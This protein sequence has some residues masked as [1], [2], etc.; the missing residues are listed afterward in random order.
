GCSGDPRDATSR[1]VL[2]A[3]RE[4]WEE[5]MRARHTDEEVDA[6]ARRFEELTEEFDL[7]AAEVDNTEDLRQ[8]ATTSDAE[9]VVKAQLIE[10]VG[11]ARAHGRSW[12]QIAVALGVARQAA[13]QRLGQKVDTGSR[14]ASPR[15]AQRTVR[16][17]PSAGALRHARASGSQSGSG[18]E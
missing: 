18:T 14:D 17:R 16:R 11:I 8:V 10:A 5:A 12:N 13:R 2:P 7:D 4:A 1:E 9:R 15:T 3:P 6:A